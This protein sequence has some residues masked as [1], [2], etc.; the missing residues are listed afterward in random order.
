MSSSPFARMFLAIMERIR[1]AV[2]EIEYIAADLGQL[3]GYS[4][5]PAVS[6][7]CV[8]QDFNGWI[9]E[10]WGD[11]TQGAEGDVVIKLGFAQ[12]L[13]SS[14]LTEPAWREQ[15]INYWDIEWKLNKALHGWSPGEFEG[16]LTR[17]ST[18]TENRPMGVRVVVLRYRMSF[19]DSSTE[20]EEVTGQR[21][22]VTFSN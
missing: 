22:A 13:D 4:Q 19:E 5:R 21:P 1:T 8:L 10:N 17:S 15:A 14:S 7:P 11:T 12:Y 2:P 6:F 16:Y 18:V 3:E 20:T 9:F